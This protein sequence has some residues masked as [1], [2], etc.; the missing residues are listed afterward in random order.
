LTDPA[1]GL[2]LG[3]RA[4]LCR[5]L[6]LRGWLIGHGGVDELVDDFLVPE[7]ALYG[8]E[9]GIAFGVPR[10]WTLLIRIGRVSQQTM[11]L[12]GCEIL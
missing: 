12:C 3:L 1:E 8:M 7:L 10:A 6:S 9:A 2:W 5:I 4:V 11:R